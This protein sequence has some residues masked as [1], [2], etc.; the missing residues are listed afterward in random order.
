MA[1][2]NWSRFLSPF[3]RRLITALGESPDWLPTDRNII[4][5]AIARDDFI[6]RFR[7]MTGFSRVSVCRA[8][9]ICQMVVFDARNGPE[10]D[11]KL[12]GLRRHWYAYFKSKVAQPLALALG[13]FEINAAGTKQV[14]DRAWNARMCVVYGE[15]VDSGEVTYKELWVEDTSRMMERF[16]ERLF[17]GAHIM[18]AVE[19][20]SLH[21]DFLDVARAIGA[22][23]VYSG[24]GKSSKAGIER[25]LRDHF[26]WREDF[27][28][29]SRRTPLIVLHVSDYDFDGEAVIGPTFAQQ[30]RRYTSHILEARIGVMPE[31]VLATKGE[32]DADWYRVK[33]LK[34]KGYIGWAE[35]KALFGATCSS[36]G[37]H[38][39]V[40]GTLPQTNAE[41]A[42]IDAH[43]HT[44]P[45]CGG[46]PYELNLETDTAYGYEVEALKTRDYYGCVVDTLLRVL[47]FEFI[48]ER[49]R[50]QCTAD[51]WQAVRHVADDV[52]AENVSFQRL[53]REIEELEMARDKFRET[54]EGGL[55]DTAYGHE[56]DWRD[57]EDDPTPDAFRKHASEADRYTQPWRP[58]SRELRTDKL[59][60]W[61][62]GD[63][64]RPADEL[65]YTE[66]DKYA[67][68]K[69][70]LEE[71]KTARPA[72]DTLRESVANEIAALQY[73]THGWVNVHD[74][75]R[76]TDEYNVDDADGLTFFGAWEAC[77]I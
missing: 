1:R 61:L 75:Y 4:T 3:A 48:V 60:T 38:W 41:S 26:G 69:R 35:R 2:T 65:H 42:K 71:Y 37:H 66:L 6:A 45:E 43:M 33:V 11:G 16:H 21:A 70:A 76:S 50:D 64:D 12:K 51:T 32:L 36:C 27:T 44:C 54:L 57:E 8:A 67:E 72:G 46:M 17:S 55:R 40:I 5:D 30:A 28:P 25:A 13:D 63:L 34:N 31:N 49:L 15:L 14:D 58:F 53:E 56:G 74:V 77:L 20:D 39:P 29:F 47:P 18:I 19:K 59:A 9:V 22:I 7:D 62:A 73:H 10:D 68:R 23:S 24:K 52:L